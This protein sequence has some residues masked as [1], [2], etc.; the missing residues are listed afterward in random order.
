MRQQVRL[1]SSNDPV[2][3]VIGARN[4]YNS[5]KY[6]DNLGEKDLDLL[7]RLSNR[8]RHESVIEHLV[9][10]YEVITSREVLQEIARH[11]IASYSVKSTRYTLKELKNAKK[12]DPDDYCII[13]SKRTNK[14]LIKQLLEEIQKQLQNGATND[15][16]KEMLPE[17]FATTII[18]TV[19]ARSLK[20]FLN[21]R[22]SE[23]AYYKIRE[24]AE[25]M[26]SEFQRVFGKEYTKAILGRLTDE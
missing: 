21:L 8:Y 5:F 2:L 10:S 13:Y 18:M 23:S 15:E 25:L 12:I 17:C 20:N 26:L 14:Q 9:V 22:L 24:I 3:P 16:V 7:D 6:M 4:C 1:L 19:N 11:R